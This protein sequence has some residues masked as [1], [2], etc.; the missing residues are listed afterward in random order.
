MKL[1]KGKK[2]ATKSGMKHNVK[3]MEKAGYSKKR[4]KGAA[5]GEVGMEKM[6]RRHESEGMKKSLMKHERAEMREL[7]KISKAVVKKRK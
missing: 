7:K 2:A 5:Y 6:A 4:A 3:V 1:E